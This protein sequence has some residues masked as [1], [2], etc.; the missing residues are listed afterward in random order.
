MPD[1]QQA[2]HYPYARIPDGAA[3]RI[4]FSVKTARDAYISFSSQKYDTENMYEI[5]LG[6]RNGVYS[7]IKRCP[8]CRD[9]VKVDVTLTRSAFVTDEEWRSFWV[10]FGDGRVKVGRDEDDESFLTLEDD[11]GSGDVSYV[12]LSTARGVVAEFKFCDLCKCAYCN[13]N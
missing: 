10:E 9:G 12:G 2:Y 3:K 7:S 11:V 6:A 1:A 13:Y 4:T 8:S 5:V